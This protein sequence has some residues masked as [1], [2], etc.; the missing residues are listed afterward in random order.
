VRLIFALSHEVLWKLLAMTVVIMKKAEIILRLLRIPL[1]AVSVFGAF[2][3]AYWL[4]SHPDMV[5]FLERE[6]ELALTWSQFVWFTAQSSLLYV[7]LMA[8]DG[9]YRLR[10]SDRFRRELWKILLVTTTWLMLIVLYFFAI[11]I[12]FFSR[13]IMGYAFLLAVSFMVFHRLVL[14]QVRR[15]L[16]K[17]GK[18]KRKVLLIG[19]GD[20]VGELLERWKKDI[21]FTVASAGAISLEVLEE[22]VERE[23]IEEVVQVGGRDKLTEDIVEYCQLNHIEYRFVPDMLEIQRTNLEMDFIGDIPLISLRSTGLTAWGRVWKRIFDLVLGF[24]FLV[25]W[26]PVMLLVALAV[27]LGSSG[28]VFYRSERISRNKCFKMWKFRSMVVNADGLKDEL[29]EEN[30]RSGPMF[31]VVDDPRVTRVGKFIRRWS[32]DELPQLLN[33]LTGDL[34]LVGPRAHLPAEIEQY[35]KHHRRVLVIKAGITGLPQVSGRSHLDFEKEVKLDVWY[36]ENW[37]LWLDVQILLRTVFAMLKGD[38]E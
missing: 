34:S 6:F 14:R 16:W 27:K 26:S 3:L 24:V 17:R 1:D 30:K 29:A 9:G 25:L 23:G 35:E 8:F 10:K 28:P 37:S 33:V 19:E 20:V 31:K 18:M 4:R 7:I 36:L 32:L 13:L 12:T 15:F 21:S 11:R 5:P 2:L 22:R 38:G